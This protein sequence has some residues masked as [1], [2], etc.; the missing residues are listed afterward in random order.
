MR[1]EWDKN[2]AFIKRDKQ[3]TRQGD[4]TVPFVTSQGAEQSNAESIPLK[5]KHNSY[6]DFDSQKTFKPELKAVGPSAP[7]FVVFCFC[8]FFLKHL[9]WH[10]G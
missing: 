4:V 9:S 5:K 8:F 6:F 3:L 7:I 1:L 10:S 2:K